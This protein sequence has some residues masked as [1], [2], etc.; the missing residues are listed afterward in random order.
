MSSKRDYYEILGLDRSAD[1]MTIK[2]AFRKLALDNHPDRNPSA[3]ATEK[4]REAQEAYDVL[5]DPEKRSLYNQFGHAGVSG[6]TSG[7]GNPF[8]NMDD[9]FAGFQTIFDDFFGG[10]SGRGSSQGPDLLFRLELEFREAILGT[11]KTIEVNR[12]AL[13]DLCE[14]KGTEPGS[15][16]ETCTICGGRGKISRSQGFFVISQTCYNCG[17]RGKVIKNPCK[18]CH[19]HGRFSK[20]QEIEVNIPAGVDTGVRLRISNEG[21]LPEQGAQRGDLYVEINVKPDK[22]FERDGADLYVKVHVPY[23]T[24]V[25]GGGIDIPLVEGTTKLNIPKL[26]ASPHL[27]T[28]KGQGVKDLRRNRRG[29]LTVEVHIEMPKDLTPAARELIEKLRDELGK[30]DHSEG[31]D[32]RSRPSSET[33]S[34]EEKKCQPKANKKKK[35]F[36]S[37]FFF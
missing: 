25:L 13:C 17:G 37:H 11:T 22:V 7:G 4:F 26:M 15:A 33:S 24:A 28:I 36:F 3:D 19:G 21:E 34:S 14:A 6:R 20:R 10:R 2:K 8:G 30:A 12:L 32:K 27:A 29:D 35:S 1:D 18:K 5:S 23:P 31:E 9:V 16:P